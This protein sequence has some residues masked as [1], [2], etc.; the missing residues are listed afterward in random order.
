MLTLRTVATRKTS[1]STA[2]A[3]TSVDTMTP[4]GVQ[5]S[6]SLAT[7]PIFNTLC[8]M[9][10][11][12]GSAGPGPLKRPHLYENLANHIAEFIEAQGLVPGDRLPPERKLAAGLGV[13][14]ATLGRAL[15]AVDRG[16]AP[17]PRPRAV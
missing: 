15:A 14:R 3:M 10:K 16:H 11:I 17:S 1:A 4:W 5:W 6:S 2:S 13:S 7:R 9:S 8:R 12:G